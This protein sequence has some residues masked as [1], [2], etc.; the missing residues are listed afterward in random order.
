[1][2]LI[3]LKPFVALLS[4]SGRNAMCNARIHH[5]AA[6]AAYHSQDARVTH[7][8]SKWH[9]S[10]MVARENHHPVA[11]VAKSKRLVLLHRS[12]QVFLNTCSSTKTT[13]SPLTLRI[14]QVMQ[15]GPFSENALSDQFLLYDSDVGLEVGRYALGSVTD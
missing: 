5:I 15:V 14:G 13:S 10:Q 1:M 2:S 9:P 11:N 4:G 3:K 7:S 12:M 6:L 8:R